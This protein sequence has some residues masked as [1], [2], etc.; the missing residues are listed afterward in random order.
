MFLHSAVEKDPWQ[1]FALASHK[2]N[3]GLAKSALRSLDAIKE[4]G[5]IVPGIESLHP[6]QAEMLTLP[7]LLGIYVAA[8]KAK[9]K[10]RGAGSRLHGSEGSSTR[11]S[12]HSFEPEQTEVTW[13]A[14]AE[15]F[16]PIMG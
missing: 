14:I 8:L 13:K 11:G 16:V 7:Y 12:E 10:E 2:N 4:N 15:K 6:T 3:L 1:V 9:D 5:G